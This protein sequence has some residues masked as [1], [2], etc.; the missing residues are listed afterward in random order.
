[1][2][3]F[4][5][6][7]RT[8]NDSHPAHYPALSCFAAIYLRSVDDGEIDRISATEFIGARLEIIL[9]IYRVLGCAYFK[10]ETP[11]AENEGRTCG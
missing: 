8:L 4:D 7:E 2:N 6:A 5:F 1:M 10:L 9:A 3:D 11:A